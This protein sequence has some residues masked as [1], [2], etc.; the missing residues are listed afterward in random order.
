[1]YQVMPVRRS[2][3][4]SMPLTKPKFAIPV[5]GEFR[6][7]KRHAELAVI[8]VFQENKV[9]IMRMVMF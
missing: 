8:W 6:H 1:M 4:L 3:S 9:V 7:L 2:L 5:H